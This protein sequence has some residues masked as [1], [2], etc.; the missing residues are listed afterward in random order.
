MFICIQCSMEALVK[1]EKPSVFS[2]SMEEHMQRVHPDPEAMVARRA[3]L[4]A[5]LQAKLEQEITGDDSHR[6][7]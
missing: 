4:E 3:V 6:P 5:E 7:A 2:E 1:G